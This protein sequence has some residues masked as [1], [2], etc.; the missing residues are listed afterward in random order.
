[1]SSTHLAVDEIH[2]AP[3]F[4][5]SLKS[6]NSNYGR[7]TFEYFKQ[8][9]ATTVECSKRY[10]ASSCV[11]ITRPPEIIACFYLARAPIELFVLF[12]S[13][14]RPHKHARGAAFIFKNSL[15]STAAYLTELLRFDDSLLSDSSIQWQAQLL[16][17]ASGEIFLAS[18]WVLANAQWAE[19]AL[20]A[21]LQVLHLQARM[22]ELESRNQTL[23]MDNKHLSEEVSDLEDKQQELEEMIEELKKADGHK[24]NGIHASRAEP[25]PSTRAMNPNAPQN[26]L[27]TPRSVAHGRVASPPLAAP[28]SGPYSP[29]NEEPIR[30]DPLAA[31]MQRDFD[32]ENKQLDRDFRRLKDTQPTF[33]DCGICMDRFQ[34]D[35]V[36]RVV[37][38]GHSYC[39]PCLR[40]WA[41]SKIRDHRHPILCPTCMAG[42]GQLEPGGRCFS[43]DYA[44]FDEMQLASFS[45]IIHCRKCVQTIFV[46]KTEYQEVQEIVCPLPGCGYAWCKACSQAIDIGGPKHSCDGSS[47]LNH[48][49]DLRGWKHCPGCQTP[50]EKIEGCNHMTC[51]SPGCNVHFCYRCGELIVQSVLRGEIKSALTRHYAKCLLF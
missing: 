31:Q 35:S 17:H 25:P 15:D 45:T 41:V 16:A 14:P 33:F 10:T 49:M 51:M 21:S 32:E 34:E 13:H 12:D 9:L 22:Q 19:V 29:R 48:L 38:C 4:S 30:V 20:D 39:R 7:P 6:V 37:S 2:K 23:E 46:D 47:E 40:D 36:A 44:I 3:V 8:L 1:T 42:K 26:P 50:A 27:G 5:K 28:R 24:M 11:I 18:E 43:S